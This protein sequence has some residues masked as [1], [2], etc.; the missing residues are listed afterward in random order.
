MLTNDMS[1]RNSFFIILKYKVI[2]IFKNVNYLG[3]KNVNY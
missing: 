3:A 2:T 1:N